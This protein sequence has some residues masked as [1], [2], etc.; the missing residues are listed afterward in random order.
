MVYHYLFSFKNTA[1]KRY[2]SLVMKGK[3]L[4]KLKNRLVV[5]TTGNPTS[6]L[7]N[8]YYF[9]YYQNNKLIFFHA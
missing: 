5:N 4:I 6:L 1:Y 7:K 9:P 2:F 8:N 3:Y